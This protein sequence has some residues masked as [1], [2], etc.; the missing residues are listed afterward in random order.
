MKY[1]ICLLIGI[2]A[3]VS[4]IDDE[5][6][7]GDKAVST[8][9]F[10]TSLNELYICEHDKLL[11]LAVPEVKQE[12]QQ[13]ALSYEWQV[14]YKVVSTEKDLNYTCE[15]YGEFP[16]RLKISNEDGAIFK[17]FTLKVPY[18]YEE[19]VMILSRYD[20][21][22]MVSY[23]SVIEGS[24][25]VKDVYRLH[26]QSV[27]LG[28]DPKGIAFNAKFGYV[29]IATE[30]PLKIIKLEHNTMEALSVIPYPE[31]R[32]ERV[33]KGGEFA[34]Y[35]TGGGRI[36]EFDCGGEYFGNTFQ[37]NLTG[38]SSITGKYPNAYLNNDV[39]FYV[40]AQQPYYT[41]AFDTDSKTLLR[42]Y[43]GT[44]TEVC[45]EAEGKSL[46]NMLMSSNRYALLVM[47]NDLGEWELIDYNVYN[48]RLEYAVSAETSGMT[49]ES[50]FMVS[51]S[52]TILFYTDGKNNI[53]R[54]NYTSKGNFPKSADYT[55]GVDGD[56]I[57]GMVLGADE[58]LLYVA[59]TA[60]EGDYRGC[61]YCYDNETK[62]LLWK[63]RG[64][65]GEIVQMIYKEK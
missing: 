40:S 1:V 16:C 45:K 9:S 43:E 4:C 50:V 17:T 25:F 32:V 12:N 61:V 53:Y 2:C 15:E 36:I 3:F 64:I 41:F 18:P 59:I 56:V 28:R 11:E 65:A 27:E 48:G 54:Y 13:K 21:R 20:G 22:S 39:V 29:Y 30:D 5:S 62:E 8:L 60:K 7:L 51:N 26:N 33:F 52:G 57:K 14:N 42:Y 23:R 31:A 10:V 38:N 35:F 58:K 49:D 63:E 24:S 19:G 37:Q 6:G 55:V 44:I 34:V 46:V 47:K